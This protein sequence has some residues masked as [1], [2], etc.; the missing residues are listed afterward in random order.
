M[1]RSVYSLCLASLLLGCGPSVG[2]QPA[3]DATEDRRWANVAPALVTEALVG[4]GRSYLHI[5][6]AQYDFWVSV[7][8]MQVAAGAHVLLGQGPLVSGVQSAALNR[9]FEAITVIEEAQVIPAHEAAA[10]V[11]LDPPEGGLDLAG[12]YARR[13]AL[14]GQRVK[15]HGRVVKASKGVF[16][17]NWYHLR[18]GS[19]G[20]AEGEDEVTVTTALD[21][22]VGDV[23]VAEGPL[24]VDRDLGFGYFYKAIL[25]D[26]S[27]TVEAR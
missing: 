20:P 5:Q 26:A 27:V 19:A 11:R 7:P 12:L 6:E 3:R 23:L 2:S 18:D 24:T 9:R 17:K 8:E 13:A 4:E 16:G 10:R 1:V 15:V 21:A 14:A 22:E 25:E